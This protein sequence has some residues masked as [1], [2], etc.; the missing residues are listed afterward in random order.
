[1]VEVHAVGEV[2][3]TVGLLSTTLGQE[4]YIGLSTQAL[5]F[6]TPKKYFGLM[7]FLENNCLERKVESFKYLE[8]FPY[9]TK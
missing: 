2:S 5:V 3:K 1:M 7:L 4:H 8:N 6:E 9:V